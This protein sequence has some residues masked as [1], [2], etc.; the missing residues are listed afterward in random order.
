M[1]LT[2][3]VLNK[4]HSK[5]KGGKQKVSGPIICLVNFTSKAPKVFACFHES[6]SMFT[7]Y[8][9]I[10]LCIT[11]NFSMNIC[12]LPNNNDLHNFYL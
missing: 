3:Y 11:Y 2:Y 8:F 4:K 9:T 1:S 6:P 12:K 7:P 5:Q 10:L